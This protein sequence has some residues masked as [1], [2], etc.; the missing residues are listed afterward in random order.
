MSKTAVGHA[1]SRASSEIERR[2]VRKPVRLGYSQIPQNSTFNRRSLAVGVSALMCTSLAM[3]Q[4]QVPEAEPVPDT[5]ET[6][7]LEKL[8]LQDKTSDTNPYAEDGAPYKAKIS[9]DSRHVKDLAETPQTIQVFTQTQLQESG[10]TDLRD[11]LSSVPGITLGTGENGNAF[12]D[13]YIIR[14]HEARSDVFVDSLHDPGMTTRESFA[15]EQVEITKGPSSTFAGRGS[16]GGAVNSITKQASTDYDFTKLQGGIGSDSYGRLTVDTN[17]KINEEVAVRAN[18][19]LGTSDVPDRDPASEDRT[20]FALSGIYDTGDRF[21]VLADVYYLDADDK[22]DLGTYIVPDGG[23]PVDNL[24][25]YLQN[26]DFLTSTVKS[27]TV[28]ANYEFTDDLRIE[29]SLRY[30]TTE[31]GYVMTGARGTVLDETDPDAPGGDNVSL[32]THQGWQE[33]DYFADQ[34]NLFADKDIGSLLHQFVFSAEFS[35]TNVKNGVYSIDNTGES[36]CVTSGRNGASPGYCMYDSSGNLVDDLNNL[37][38]REI[39]RGDYDSDFKISTV[40]L[41]AMDTIDFTDRLTGFFGV[42]MDSFDYTN[43]LKST[44]NETG[45]ST[46]TKYAYDD[47]LWNG[48]LG[49]VMKVAEEGNV[50]ANFSS[51]SNI[52]GGESDLGGNCGYGGLCGDN[53]QV[54]NSEPETSHNFE[55]G[56]KWDLFDDKLLATFAVFQMTKSDVME[57][58]GEDDYETLGTLN[59]GKNR[60][61]GVE[62]SLAG[63]LTETVSAVA[64]FSVMDSEILK[65][66]DEDSV[67]RVLSN[68]ADKSAFAQLRVEVTPKVVI[69][70]AVT[71]SSETYAGQPDSAAGYN[72]DIGQYSYKVPAYTVL[73]VFS[74]YEFNKQLSVR[75]NVGNVTDKDYYLASY[76]SGAF[77]YK[78]DAL[79]TRLTVN[80]EF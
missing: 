46:L 29:N 39:T 8:E 30:G 28:R 16:T 44:N 70:G 61:R 3:A 71:Y 78:G 80:Y 51:S 12:G 13:R 47:V 38:G 15:V 56:T 57:S 27:G 11:Q 32:S 65:S 36:N 14:G 53:T 1:L 24:P 31:N 54:G 22:P 41:A 34:I 20:G 74:S 42:R 2:E 6:L 58:I 23:G 49:V 76:R 26:Q 67:G 50:Y 66:Y 68:F 43:T 7:V 35:K 60:I 4:S 69:G 18:V 73:D 25:V 40:S 10:K 17:Q 55:L 52:N 63:N 59:T 9:G 48:H 5:E 33:I 72:T 64:G 79:N 62:F 21:S 77:A 75:L 45:E 37:M 19:L